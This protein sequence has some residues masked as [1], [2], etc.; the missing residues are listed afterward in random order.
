[1][2]QAHDEVLEKWLDDQIEMVRKWLSNSNG[3][4]YDQ[5]ALDAFDHVKDKLEELWAAGERNG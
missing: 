5:G 2:K 3:D 1:M 4:S